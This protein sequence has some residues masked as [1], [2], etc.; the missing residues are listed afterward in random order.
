[1]KKQFPEVEELIL[2]TIDRIIGTSV[3]VKMDEY[4]N[5][6]G[7]INFSEVAPGR[8]RNIRDYIKIGQKIVVKVLRVD[9]SK[10]HIDLSLRRVTLKERKEIAEKHRKQKDFFVMLNFA[11]ID[12]N[13]LNLIKQKSKEFSLDEFLDA[14]DKRDKGFFA[15]VGISH[16]E[17]KK[18]FEVLDEKIKNKRVDVRAKFSL[19]CEL[20]EG[21]ERIKR[22]LNSISLNGLTITYLGAPNY[23]IDLEGTDYKE[24]KKKLKEILDLFDKKAKES[25]CIFE[26]Q[27]D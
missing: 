22:V 14:L 5:K 10:N 6:E 12:K 17:I 21:I 4:N 27:E 20:P 7:V 24:L 15:Q 2:V 8:I 19:K 23:I 9:E 1:M 13:K 18:V 3:F 16:D 26:V 11:L 25:N